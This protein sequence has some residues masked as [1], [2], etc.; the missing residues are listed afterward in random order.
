[1]GENSTM[2][3]QSLT[4]ANLKDL[5]LGKIDEAF[6]RHL[7]RAA[8]DCM[9]RPTESKPRV[10]TLQFEVVPV[11]VDGDCDEVVVRIQ[12]TSKVPTHKTRPYSLAPRRNG[13]LVFNPDSPT[14]VAQGTFLPD[15]DDDDRRG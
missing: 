3:L 15:D 12:T 2:S 4:L 1:M 7:A 9:D 14:N 11:E 6:Q 13:A 8:I 5:D 10:V